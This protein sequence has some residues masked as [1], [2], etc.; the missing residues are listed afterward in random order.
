MILIVDKTVSARAAA[1][2]HTLYSLGCPCAV[3][4]PPDMHLYKPFRLILT[5]ADV[6]GD[7]R[8]MPFDSVR[9]LVVGGGFVN[10]ALNAAQYEDEDSAIRA[11]HAYLMDEMGVTDD[12]IL[13]FG[14]MFPPSL[15]VAQDFI[16]I[17][18]NMV[19][20]SPIESMIVKLTVG[21]SCECSPIAAEVIAEYCSP[22]QSGASA[23]SVPVHISHINAKAGR[24]LASPL[25]L[26]KKGEG[27]YSA[28][29]AHSQN[30]I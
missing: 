9:A 6:L 23:P 29:T 12:R 25:I 27:Y 4:V 7:V 30:G 17:C 21:A 13:P 1:L 5:Y 19:T 11:A 26:S 10:S 14:V 8:R 20:L 28:I 24:H 15:F 16:E 3:C 22:K 18:G 2:R